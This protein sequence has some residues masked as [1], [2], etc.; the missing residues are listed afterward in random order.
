MEEKSWTVCASVVWSSFQPNIDGKL[1]QIKFYPLNLFQPYLCTICMYC[2][3]S[4]DPFSMLLLPH[5][6]AAVKCVFDYFPSSLF[7]WTGF[8]PGSSV[9][10]ADEIPNV[11]P[12]PLGPTQS[13]LSE[14]I[15]IIFTCSGTKYC[16]FW[17][18]WGANP[19]SFDFIYLLLPSLYRWATAAPQYCIFLFLPLGV[20][21][22]PRR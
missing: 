10:E 3:R 17:P 13:A 22:A 20:K 19:G 2:Y 15:Y 11:P 8:N 14:R 18:G 9:P 4:S 21:M 6:M 7:H 5:Y 12:L 1:H 16:I